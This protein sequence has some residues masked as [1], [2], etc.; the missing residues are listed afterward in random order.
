VDDTTRKYEHPGLSLAFLGLLLYLLLLR[1]AP[2]Q[3]LRGAV[4]VD[5]EPTRVAALVQ[6]ER[7]SFLRPISLAADVAR[8]VAGGTFSPRSLLTREQ[9]MH[10]WV[11]SRG[12]AALLRAELRWQSRAGLL[13]KTLDALLAR[14]S[15]EASL[16]DALSRLKAEAE[17]AP[18]ARPRPTP[19][20]IASLRGAHSAAC[21]LLN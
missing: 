15:R 3:S 1:P 8:W 21:A 12:D 13:G 7:L 20:K 17:A 2:E 5:A 4:R 19:S 18:G 16:A 14:G 9:Q 10:V 11:E 6:N